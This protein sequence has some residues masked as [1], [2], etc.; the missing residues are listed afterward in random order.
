MDRGASPLPGRAGGAAGLSSVRGTLRD[1]ESLR[2]PLTSLNRTRAPDNRGTQPPPC[3]PI[4]SLPA[5]GG[6][7]SRHLSR[8]DKQP[9]TV[10]TIKL[11]GAGP[12]HT[13]VSGRDPTQTRRSGRE[14]EVAEGMKR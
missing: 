10:S 1:S 5:V 13:L 3:T 9:P 12:H 2:V 14:R 7:L 11:R 4:R 8:L 6:C